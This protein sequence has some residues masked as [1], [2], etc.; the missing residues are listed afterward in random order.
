MNQKEFEAMLLAVELEE[1]CDTCFGTGD[2]HARRYGKCE[3]CGGSGTQ[4][5]EIGKKFQQA[6]RDRL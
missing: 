1:K 5:T 6:L 4:L 3:S 2:H